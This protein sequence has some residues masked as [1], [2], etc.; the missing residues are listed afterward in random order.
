M[1]ARTS[2]KHRRSN[3][4]GRKKTKRVAVRPSRGAPGSMSVRKLRG[5]LGISRKLFS[6]A[7]GFSERAIADWEAAKPMSEGCLQKMRELS[8]LQTALASVIRD[9]FVG[10]WL[11]SPNKA[12]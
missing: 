12:F 2:A 3:G 10:T 9:G 5:Q 8:R 1:A 11:N 6:R 7:V 4:A